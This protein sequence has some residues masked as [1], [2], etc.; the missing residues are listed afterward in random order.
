MAGSFLN[1]VMRPV[2]KIRPRLMLKIL[3]R[4]SLIAAVLLISNTALAQ[5]VAPIRYNEGPGIKL[6]DSLVFH[7]GLEV[8]GRYDTNARYGDS[9]NPFVP[10]IGAPYLRLVGHLHLATLSPQRLADGDNKISLPNVAFRLKSAVAYREYFKKEVEHLRAVEVDA[11]M[12]LRLFPY[13][14]VTV[15]IFDDYTRTVPEWSGINVSRNTNR[16]GLKLRIKPG[17]GRLEFKVGYTFSFDLIDESARF[18]FTNKIGH[19]MRLTAKWRLLPKT[20]VFLEATET[21]ITYLDP[22]GGTEAIKDL[23]TSNLIANSDSYPLRI[24]MGFSGLI[25]PRFSVMLKAGYANAFYDINDSYNMMVGQGEFTFFISP[26]AKIK[27]GFEHSFA[28]SF[29]SNY[30]V[31]ERAYLG[32]DHFIINRILLHLSMEYRFRQHEGFPPTTSTQDLNYHIVKADIGFDYKIFEWFYVGIGY[33][34]ELR[35]QT[36]AALQQTNGKYYNDFNKHQIFGKIGL[37]Y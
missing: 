28:D 31:D 19:E 23:K 17:G 27:G 14:T 32:Y 10:V 26:L 1:D 5:F 9:S 7:P 34:L 22:T 37:S 29:L 21:I 24:Y 8:E 6:T 12:E 25:T 36:T 18:A 11:G 33:N 16:G 4:A 2:R 3:R 30:F 35:K 20:A 15:S 13:S